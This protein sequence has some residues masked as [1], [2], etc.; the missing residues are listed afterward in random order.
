MSLGKECSCLF[1]RGSM[2]RDSKWEV[3]SALPGS[4]L[5]LFNTST[6]I[7]AKEGSYL[8][9]SCAIVRQTAAGS[10]N[11]ISPRLKAKLDPIRPRLINRETKL[12][13]MVDF[14][15]PGHPFIHRILGALVSSSHTSISWSRFSRVPSI[16]G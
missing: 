10:L 15:D 11:M 9:R 7:E 5:P 2:I 3:I 14:P 1:L 13:A 6:K 16:H 4:T 12:D 8:A